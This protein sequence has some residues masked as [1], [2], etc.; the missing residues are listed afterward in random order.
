MARRR[1][2]EAVK[3]RRRRALAGAAIGAFAAGLL[4]AALT[5]GGD[6]R[7]DAGPAA[8]A[9]PI[10]GL[11]DRELTGSRLVAGY[12]GTS[13][14]SGLRQLIA[15]GGIS[16]VI[17]FD[18]NVSSPGRTAR[19]IADLQAIERPTGLGVPLVVAVD[20]EG[21]LVRRTSGPPVASAAEMGERGRD[22]A[23]R[24][25]SRTASSLRSHGIN[26]DLAPVLDLARPGSAI[27][28]EGRSFGAMPAKVADVG[29]GGFA[30]GLRDDGVAATAKHFPGLG[31]ATTNTD[32]AAQTI[33]LPAAAI[34]NREEA[35]FRA[36][37][38]AG[39]EMVMLSLATYPA[40]GDRPAALDR[41]IATGELRRRVGFDGVAITDSLD[42]AA[43]R[44]F[45]DVDTV[46]IAAAR[47]GS[48][49]LL[50]GDWRTA[51]TVGR[52]LADRLRQGRLER[53]GFEDSARRVLELRSGLATGP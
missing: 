36:F 13:P 27:A 28:A 38:E 53:A 42:A 22:Y 11:D 30:A 44:A 33:D 5:G 14:P 1:N 48:D 4:V 7:T 24:Q 31:G 25:G 3:S 46:A 51:R 37:A 41:R 2:D 35:P 15:R 49:L 29:V 45:G 50:Y 39:G 8:A 10:A 9:D 32:L 52:V 18:E 6:A 17:L 43:A 20:Q 19:T 47:A 34:R 40:L 21:G 16:G 23:R 26:V 12:D